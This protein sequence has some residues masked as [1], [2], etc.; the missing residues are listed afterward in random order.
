M[1]SRIA[2]SLFWIGRYVERAGNLARALEVHLDLGV[3]GELAAFSAELCRAMGSPLS[4]QPTSEEVWSALGLDPTSPYSMVSSVTSCRES[5]RRAREV[6]AVSTWEVINRSYHRVSS[7]RLIA[8]RPVLACRDVRDFCAMTVGTLEETMTRDQAWHFLVTGRDIERVDM[9]ARVL[10]TVAATPARSTPHHQLLRAC[11]AQQAY[12]T[13]RGADDTM[14]GAVDFLLRDRLSPRSVVHCLTEACA[15][16]AAL[17]PSTP[18]T[19]FEDDAQRLLGRACSRIEYLAPKAVMDE[20]P[21][22]THQLQEACRDAT[23]AL[24]RRYFEGALVS[25]WRGR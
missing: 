21:A 12:L 18:R 14:G 23:V 11:A 3:E 5:A 24:T 25:Q 22:V 20:L 13:T 9:T 4:S 2:E 17:E 1:L 19:G 6:L 7:G 15:S 16:L 10:S 8:M